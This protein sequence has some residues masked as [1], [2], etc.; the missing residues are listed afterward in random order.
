M[1]D[2]TLDAM[3]QNAIQVYRYMTLNYV[4]NSAFSQLAINEVTS[5][6]LA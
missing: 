1:Q 2:T 5:A 4:K 3:S 6:M